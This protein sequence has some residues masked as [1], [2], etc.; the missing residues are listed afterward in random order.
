MPT[1][2]GTLDAKVVWNEAEGK[3]LADGNLYI[4]P[5]AVLQGVFARIGAE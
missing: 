4:G 5:E 1:V 3:E 2:L